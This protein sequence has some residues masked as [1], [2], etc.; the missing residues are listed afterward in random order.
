MSIPQLAHGAR[1]Y[2]YINGYKF[3]PAISVSVTSTSQTHPIE[4]IDEVIP[5][6]LAPTRCQVHG[7]VQCYRIVGD[8]GLEGLGITDQ[9]ANIPRQK[10]FSFALKDRITGKMLVKIDYCMVDS[11]QWQIGSKALMMGSFS[12]TGISWTNEMTTS[13]MSNPV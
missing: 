8:G 11:Q 4:G 7:V 13:G 1:I 12:F 5:S 6:E 3:G 2:A 9:F 10:Y